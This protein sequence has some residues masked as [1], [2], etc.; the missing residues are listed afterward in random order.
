MFLSF[1][2]R[3]VLVVGVGEKKPKAL[4]V[5]SVIATALS[6]FL[7][8]EF[9]KGLHLIIHALLCRSSEYSSL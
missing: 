4:V 9:Q 6:H 5:E 8:D 2:G 7:D 3:H 1:R